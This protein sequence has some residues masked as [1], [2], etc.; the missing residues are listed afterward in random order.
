M[1][2]HYIHYKTLN[3]FD[4]SKLFHCLFNYNPHKKLFFI[5]LLDRSNKRNNPIVLQS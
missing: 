5:I 4:L 2:S 3:F 1:E